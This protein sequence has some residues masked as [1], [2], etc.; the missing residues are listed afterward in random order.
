MIYLKSVIKRFAGWIFWET[1]IP[2]GCSAPYILGLSIGR[3][4]HKVEPH[5][6]ESEGAADE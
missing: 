5:P 3:M 6:N 2:L 1:D 4:P